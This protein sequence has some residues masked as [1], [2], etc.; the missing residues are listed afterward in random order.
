M[1][2]G[3]AFGSCEQFLKVLVPLRKLI[4]Q[5]QDICVFSDDGIVI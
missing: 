4:M 3:K 1:D 2:N 5:Q